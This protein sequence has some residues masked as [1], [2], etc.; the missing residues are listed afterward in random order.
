MFSFFFNFWCDTIKD[1]HSQHALHEIE[2]CKKWNKIQLHQIHCGHRSLYKHNKV[3]QKQQL[4]C[5]WTLGVVTK[6]NNIFLI[7]LFWIAK[8]FFLLISLW[9]CINEQIFWHIFIG[10]LLLMKIETITCQIGLCC[11]HAVDYTCPAIT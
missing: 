9:C 2:P 5:I 8:L 6:W 10:N 3:L 7:M 4:S 11:E 1:Y